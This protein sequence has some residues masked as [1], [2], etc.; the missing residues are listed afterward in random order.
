MPETLSIKISATE[1]A[2]LKALSEARKVPISALIREGLSMVLAESSK[3]EQPSCYDLVAKELENLW[4]QG[5][6]GITDL[7]SNKKHM[8]NFGKSSLK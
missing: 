6:S 2:R 8:E 7:S 4:A 3:S 5:G 1:K